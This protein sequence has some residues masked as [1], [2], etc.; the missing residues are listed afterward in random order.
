MIAVHEHAS[1]LIVLQAKIIYNFCFEKNTAPSWIKGYAI[2]QTI[3]NEK[4]Y[5]G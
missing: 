1:V 2:Y 3:R 5:A 4:E